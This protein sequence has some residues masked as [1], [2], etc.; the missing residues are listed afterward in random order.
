M[1]RPKKIRSTEAISWIMLAVGASALIVSVVYASTILA[2]IGLGLAFWG[3]ILL[4]IRDK[5]YA[6]KILLDASVL[7]SLTT[8][9]QIIQDLNFEGNA[10]YLPP[11]YFEDPVAI[12]IYIP[13]QE[14][15]SLPKPE[16]T[17][18]Y[19]KQLLV[20]NSQ[21]ILGIFLTPPAAQLTK[22]FEKILKTSFIIVDLE[23][24]Q[25]DL[26]KLFVEDLEI[27][28]DLK[29]QIIKSSA[30]F[31]QIEIDAIHAFLSKVRPFQRQQASF[32][33]TKI[34][35]IHVKITNSIYKDVCK[36][37]RKLSRICGQ[38]GC[39]VCSAIAC[40]IAKASGKPVIIEKTQD[41]ADGRIIEVHYRIIEE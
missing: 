36:E 40:A 38:I 19:E 18:K 22:L 3:A 9:N 6:R 31:S 17:R 33:Q 1:K 27:A 37:S 5:E 11:Q 2:F 4:Y 12:K 7:P 21:D 28:E 15:R 24:L 13:K 41:S 14:N 34:D 16:Q 25:R 35:A 10:V 26:S 20:G 23:N 30:S 8:I 39:P 29:I 32:S